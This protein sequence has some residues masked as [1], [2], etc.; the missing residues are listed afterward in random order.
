MTQPVL[1]SLPGYA[2]PGIIML[3]PKCDW[4]LVDADNGHLPTSEVE[5]IYF[6]T[7]KRTARRVN[8]M[9]FCHHLSL[10]CSV[11]R[12][13]MNRSS[14][15]K[16][17]MSPA[18]HPKTT[19]L[20]RRQW[21][22]A[23]EMYT[24]EV[25][26]L[27]STLAEGQNKVYSDAQVDN[28]GLGMERIKAWTLFLSLNLSRNIVWVSYLKLISLFLGVGDMRQFWWRGGSKYTDQASYCYQIHSRLWPG[29][30]AKDLKL[31]TLG[32]W[33]VQCWKG[34]W[35]FSACN[36]FVFGWALSS[37][38]AFAVCI[39]HHKLVFS[40]EHSGKVRW[41][42]LKFWLLRISILHCSQVRPHSSVLHWWVRKGRSS[43]V[44]RVSSTYYRQV[45]PNT[46]T[47]MYININTCMPNSNKYTLTYAST[48]THARTHAHHWPL[49]HTRQV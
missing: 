6:A 29:H 8:V 49:T 44:R 40:F 48:R 23:A 34:T 1:I 25:S 11:T 35:S 22:S 4:L 32:M 17:I 45:I 18:R 21:V 7:A 36:S 26:R 31:G 46:H 24:K 2:R 30:G 5:N 33:Q 13:W 43:T 9:L 3:I 28:G 39:V 38:T 19:Q 16:L 12:T 14:S 47:Y 42:W 41:A 10:A 15:Q 27:D 20:Q 37:G